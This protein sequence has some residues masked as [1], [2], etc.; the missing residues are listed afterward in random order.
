MVKVLTDIDDK[1]KQHRDRFIT[2]WNR[3]VVSHQK[4]SLNEKTDI[5]NYLLNRVLILKYVRDSSNSIADKTNYS[6]GK[7]W[8]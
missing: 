4:K 3:T 8:T 7:S 5:W 2:T 1:G 6:M